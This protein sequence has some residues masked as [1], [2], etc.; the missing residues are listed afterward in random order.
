[1]F[2]VCLWLIGN[3]GLQHD[4]EGYCQRFCCLFLGLSL[5]GLVHG[6]SSEDK[7]RFVTFSSSLF[8]ECSIE[9][10]LVSG[11]TKKEKRSNFVGQWAYKISVVIWLALSAQRTWN[12]S[13]LFWEYS[14]VGEILLS[15][16]VCGDLLISLYQCKCSW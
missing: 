2:F 1:M 3:R 7:T 14:W 8:L 15:R 6:R 4:S 12:L 9:G 5:L 16:T 11:L 13:S 10:W